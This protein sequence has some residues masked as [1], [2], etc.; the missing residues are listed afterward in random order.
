MAGSHFH[1]S[2]ENSILALTVTFPTRNSLESVGVLYPTFA[3]IAHSDLRAIVV[4][5]GVTKQWQAV[6]FSSALF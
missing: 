2:S 4:E 1:F 6:G 5:A 3:F